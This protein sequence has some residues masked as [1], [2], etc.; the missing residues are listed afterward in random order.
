M[1]WLRPQGEAAVI[2][3]RGGVLTE[4]PGEE[5]VDLA[6]APYAARAGISKKASTATARNST[7]S[8]AP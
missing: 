6:G 8:F 1:A 2:V 3:P 7:G 4:V 5:L